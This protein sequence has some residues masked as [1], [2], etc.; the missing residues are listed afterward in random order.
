MTPQRLLRAGSLFVLLLFSFVVFAQNRTI[1]GRVADTTGTGI[2]GATVAASGTSQGTATDESGQFSLSVPQ[3]VTTLV[4]SSVGFQRQE[5]TIGS[6]SQLNITLQPSVASTLNEVV[7]VG[8][9]TQRRGDVTGSVTKIGAANLNQGPITNPLQ[10]IAGRA[11]GVTITQSGSEPGVA[12]NVRIRGI[13]SL[14][15]GND[16]LVVVDGIQ[17]NLDLLNQVPPSEIESMD[18]LK[19]ASA[20]A[21]YGSRGAAGVIIITTRKGRAGRTTL[22]YS[23]N[24]SIETVA[25]KFDMLTADEWRAEAQRRGIPT[26][27]DYGGNTNWFDEITRNA[28]TQNHNIAFSGGAA[29]FN[30]RASLTAILQEG[31]IINSGLR[32][33][34][35]RFQGTQKALDNKLTVTFNLNSAITTN[36]WNNASNNLGNSLSR[37]PTD[38]IY[39]KSVSGADSAYFIDPQAFSYVNPYARAKEIID[40]SETNNLFGSLRADLEIVR[41]LTAGFFGSWRKVNASYGSYV[42]P[43]TTRSD[44]ILNKGIAERNTSNTNE[45]L[46]DLSLNYRK[47]WGEHN[48]DVIGVYEWQKAIYD[49]FTSRGRGFVNDFLTYNDLESADLAKATSGDIQSYKNDRTIISF[50]GRMNY[51]FR[52]RYYLTAS[53]RRDGSSVFGA[54]HKWGNFPA[55]SIAWRISQENFMA[56]QEMFNDL[57]L[58]AGYGVTG[59]QQGLAPQGS[60]QLVGSSGTTYFGG[61]LIPNFAITQNANADLRWET[62]KMANVGIDFTILKNRLTATVDYYNGKTENL[63]FDYSVNVGSQ[64][65]F[66]TVKANVGTVLNEGLE[67]GLNYDLVKT[68]DLSVV[69]A[70]NFTTNKNTVDEL[71]GTVN[72]SGIPTALNTDFV[73]WGSG[74]TTGVAGTNNGISYLVEGKPIGAFWLFRHAGVDANGNQLIEDINKDGRLDDGTFVNDSTVNRDRAFAGQALPKFTYAFTPSVTYKNLDM[75]M[76]WRGVQG[77]KI[78]NARR[79]TLSAMSQFGQSN[80][81][82]SALESNISNL[83]RATDYWLEDGSY[84]RLEN[85][86]IGYRIPVGSTRFI[87]GIRASVTG[88]NLLVFTNYSGIDPELSL[89]GGNGFG[90]DGGIYPRTRSVAVGLNIIFK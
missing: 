24:A 60:L 89:S 45:K 79:A 4:I 41:G 67:I 72:V 2:R 59:N 21:I 47:A 43:A 19:D 13:T 87:S 32:N 82:Q 52:S 22:E 38:P 68:K 5:V 17:G 75:N 88:N 86:T 57:K 28:S 34:I 53:L 33:Y 26:T 6:Q 18:I 31:L 25:K 10:Q 49:G 27:A 56:G 69:L 30:Y 51:N 85:L 83:D 55:A 64:F 76:V 54:N 66:N 81:L 36:K 9:G 29:N 84:L 14:I 40:G 48:L 23:G 35:G 20:T 8:Y 90:I 44:A 61:Q 11:A 78:F 77:N 70:G 39:F 12:P 42:S 71:S 50:L 74:G 15:G 3:S 37:R 73:T 58:R 16:P 1:T 62:R 65:L 80:V 63:L 46:M 7:V